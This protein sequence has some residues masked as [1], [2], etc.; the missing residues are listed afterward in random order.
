LTLLGGVLLVGGHVGLLIALL[1][2]AIGAARS[3]RECHEFITMINVNDKALMAII[4][5]PNRRPGVKTWQAASEAADRLRENARRVDAS[6]ADDSKLKSITSTYLR[7]V[8]RWC[9]AFADARKQG[10]LSPESAAALNEGDD[11]R[12]RALDEFQ[13][14][15][16]AM[17]PRQK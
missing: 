9:I 12:G 16:P 7:A 6:V 10:Q 3:A 4:N 14:N 15:F 8:D 1:I 17:A 13:R 11:L 5:D 2:P